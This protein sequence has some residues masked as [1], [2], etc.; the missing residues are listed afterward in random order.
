M[1]CA[2]CGGNLV[3]ETVQEEVKVHQDHVL[4]DV[5]AEVC[6]DCHERYFEEGVIDRLIVIKRKLTEREFKL[7]KLG[8]VYKAV[9]L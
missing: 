2:L 1:K 9:G 7:P 3:R 6:Q 5:E 4:V 8:E